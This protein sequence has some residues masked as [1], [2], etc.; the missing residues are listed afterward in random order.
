MP[1]GRKLQSGPTNSSAR[2]EP[3]AA[4]APVRKSPLLLVLV[5]VLLVGWLSFLV[6]L[7]FRG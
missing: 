7:A 3:R 5:A 6:V 1:R 2:A 4:G